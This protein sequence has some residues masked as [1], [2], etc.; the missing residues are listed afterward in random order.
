MYACV[1]LFG[2]EGWVGKQEKRP[3]KGKMA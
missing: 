2:E 3:E 1:C